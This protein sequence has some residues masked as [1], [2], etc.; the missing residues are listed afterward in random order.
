MNFKAYPVLYLSSNDGISFVITN[1]V[2]RRLKKKLICLLHVFTIYIFLDFGFSNFFESGKKLRTW[3][4][5]PPYAAPE[6]FEGKEYFG[7][8][9]DIWVSITWNFHILFE[10][11]NILLL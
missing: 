5:S 2:S 4:G 1:S 6:L 7:P 9:V 11:E 3:C 8:E 10:H